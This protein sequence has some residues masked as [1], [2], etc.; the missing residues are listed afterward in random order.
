MTPLLQDTDAL[1]MPVAGTPAPKG[2]ASTGDP[3][4]CARW[5][6]AGLPAIS[7]PSG[8]AEDGLPLAIQLVAGEEP[9]LLAVAAWCEAT[10]GFSSAPPET[11]PS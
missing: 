7:L 1:L 2:L 10:L 9:G 8:L 3:T 6:I 11:V 4:F 5:T